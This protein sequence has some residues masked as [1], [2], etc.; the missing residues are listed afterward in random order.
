MKNDTLELLT[1]C[2]AG[3]KMAVTSIDDVLDNVK[4]QRLHSILSDC[5]EYHQQLGSR[6]HMLLERCGEP[7]KGVDPVARGMSW[8]KTSV[9][10]AMKPDDKT[11]ADLMVDGCN[12][13]V[14]SLIRYK[15]QY[16][17]ASSDARELA[18]DLIHSEEQLAADL[19]PYL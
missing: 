10:L 1:E 5:K 18:N 17:A 19:R 14:K 11:V 7:T 12:M 9:K 8:V 2:N 6:T 16:A 4:D 3:I 15:N 13:G